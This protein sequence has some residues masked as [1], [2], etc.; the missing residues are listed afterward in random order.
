MLFGLGVLGSFAFMAIA[1][2]MDAF[3]VSLSI[4]LQNIRLKRVVLLGMM[5][6][7]FHCLLPFI[8][9]IIGNILSLK[10][11]V[12]AT[13]VGGLLL[14]AIGFYMFYAAFTDRPNALVN[15]TGFKLVTISFA[16]SVDSF[17][18]GLGLGML[19]MRTIAVI[20]MFGIVSML[21]AW[22]GMLI[23]KKVH[24]HLSKYSEAFGGV[25]LFIFGM[26]IIFM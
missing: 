12:V 22:L 1:L 5:I 7:L 18:V 8:G 3:S 25:I 11:E 2:S 19:G 13:M 23:G 24:G 9:I 20:F 21:F 6:G 4:G 15:L 10:L 26:R 17:P 14:V 16:V